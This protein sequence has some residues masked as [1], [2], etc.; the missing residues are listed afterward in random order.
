M[1]DHYEI[2]SLTGERVALRPLEPEEQGQIQRWAFESDLLTQTCHPPVVR[3]IAHT[4]HERA[5][6]RPEPTRG[7]FAV[8]MRGTGTLIGR[9]TYYELNFRNRSAEIGYLLAPAA[10][11]KGFA[12]EAVSLLLGYLFDGLGLNKVYAQTA[13]INNASTKLLE[14]LRF[15]RDGV[16]REHHLQ[17]GIRHDD[18]LYSILVS[19]WRKLRVDRGS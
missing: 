8:I 4:V 17:G 13:S 5:R 14:A 2:P 16:L 6:R 3:S 7:S 19:E 11:G 18:F 15:H 10:R 9:V 1:P 12:R